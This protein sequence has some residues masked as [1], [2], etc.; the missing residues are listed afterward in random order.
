MEPANKLAAFGE[1]GWPARPGG[2]EKRLRRQ[3]RLGVPG[4]FLEKITDG[5][6]WKDAHPN[7]L[8]TRCVTES[9]SWHLASCRGG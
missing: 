4:K 1:S 7:V 3:D 5:G 6:G 9:N 2:R 8:L